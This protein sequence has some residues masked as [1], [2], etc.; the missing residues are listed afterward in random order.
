VINDK[1]Y[2]GL[3]ITLIEDVAVLQ[4]ASVPVTVYTVVAVGEAITD[5][6]VVALKPNAGDQV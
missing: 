2:F 3:S 4:L 5:A 1:S 6:P